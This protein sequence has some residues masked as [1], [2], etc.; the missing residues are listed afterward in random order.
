[1]QYVAQPFTPG[2]SVILQQPS[3]ATITGVVAQVTTR[4]CSHLPCKGGI[5]SRCWL[6]A[7]LHWQPVAKVPLRRCHGLAPWVGAACVLVLRQQFTAAAWRACPMHNPTMHDA[8]MQVRLLRTILAGADGSEI[9]LSNRAISDM[10]ITNV[11]R[12]TMPSEWWDL[13]CFPCGFGL[14]LA[15]GVG[16]AS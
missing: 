15:G 7:A 10:V 11:S 6:A 3:G 4:V 14:K 12:Q 16:G 5:F 8:A 1:M 2:D 13:D 9:M